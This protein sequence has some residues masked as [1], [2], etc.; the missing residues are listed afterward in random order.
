MTIVFSWNVNGF[1]SVLKKGFV[2]WLKE[3]KPDILCLQETK[4][5]N[6]DIETNLIPLIDEYQTYWNCAKRPGYS[7]TGILTKIAPIKIHSVDNPIFSEE[8]RLQIIEFKKFTLVNSYWPNSQEERARLPYK[9]QFIEELTQ[10]LLEWV[11]QKKN[12]LICGDFNIAHTEIDL[13][14]PKENENHAGFYPEEREALTKFFN[15]GF[16]DTF[17]LF[18]KEGGHYTWWSYRTNARERN[19]GWR[20]DYHVVNQSF[21][22]KVKHS[23][24]LSDVY[25]SDH[26]PIGIELEV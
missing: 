12:L 9:L 24:I 4:L 22:K 21:V 3:S 5:K 26:C 6:A 18:C 8:G 2:K 20:I 25:G 1:R 17:R 13:A 15:A 16:V 23:W 10:L 19:I 11:K 7:G 14:R